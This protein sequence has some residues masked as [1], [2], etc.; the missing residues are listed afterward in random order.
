MDI[1]QQKIVL[2]NFIN[3]LNTYQKRSL[4]HGEQMN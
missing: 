4:V 2:T 1:N 3:I